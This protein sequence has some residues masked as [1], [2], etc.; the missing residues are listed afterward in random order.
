MHDFTAWSN[1]YVIT[2]SASAALTGLVF[3][4]VTL[5]AARRSQPI[6]DRHTGTA[7][8]STPTVLHFCAA[9][10]VSGIMTAPWSSP[11][12]PET[13]LAL[14]GVFGILYVVRVTIR[15]RAFTAYQPDAEDWTWFVIL[16]FVAYITLTAGALLLIGGSPLALFVVAAA[17][18]LLIFI[19]IHNAWDLVTYLA[20]EVQD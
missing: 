1:F 3:V 17:T 13:I 7:T 2:G 15:A 4:V 18:M 5:S 20:I 10:L 9:F 6:E 11:H 8:F 12:Y 16:P 14:C 19:G